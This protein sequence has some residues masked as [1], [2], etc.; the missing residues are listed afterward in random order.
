MAE[1]AGVNVGI[2]GVGAIGGALIERLLNAN[3]RPSDI[4][5]C[6]SKEERRDEV[7]K[8]FG[9]KATADPKEAAHCDIVVLAVPPL[10]VRKLLAA[11]GKE[12]SD[13]SLIISFAGAIPL[14]TLEAVLPPSVPVVRVNPNSPL[15]VGAGFNPV[16]YGSSLTDAKRHLADRFLALL[17]DNPEVADRDMNLYTAITAVGPTYFLPIFE[18]LISAGLAGGLSHEAAV[19]AALETARGSAEMIANRPESPDQLK[20]FTGLRPLDDALVRDLISQAIAT[21]L[22][23]MNTVQQEAAL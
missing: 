13:R 4:V 5:A 19:T 12:L 8:R 2:I 17:G 15:L 6:E 7:G 16:V 9:V 14:A 18:A 23:R 20:Y 10:E 3:V 22:S 11:V 21:A 1:L